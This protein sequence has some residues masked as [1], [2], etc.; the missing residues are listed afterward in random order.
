MSATDPFADVEQ[1]QARI[2]EVVQ[3]LGEAVRTIVGMDTVPSPTQ[4]GLIDREVN[5]ARVKIKE[6]RTQE[7][8]LLDQVAADMEAR[9]KVDRTPTWSETKRVRQATDPRRPN[10]V[11][12]AILIELAKANTYATYSD[13]P[14]QV[15][16]HRL[17]LALRSDDLTTA[18]A[19]R[20]IA[21]RRVM[22]SGRPCGPQDLEADTPAARRHLLLTELG[23][24]YTGYE[25]GLDA[26]LDA[27]AALDEARL[28]PENRQARRLVEAGQHR[29]IPLNLAAWAANDELL[30][31]VVQRLGEA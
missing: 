22:A 8:M 11:R 28:P 16:L 6:L 2:R 20:D 17:R 23:T 15:L 24:L 29:R 27:V 10:Q 30:Q 13:A 4:Q 31:A 26:L 3:A 18:E 1:V 5:Q 12:E 21:L 7:R 25:P 19:V 14:P 9:S